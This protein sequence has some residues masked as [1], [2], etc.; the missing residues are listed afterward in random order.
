VCPSVTTTYK[1]R[2]VKPDSSQ[3]S[4]EVM[5][6]VSGGGCG[7]PVIERFV[8]T[9][10]DVAAGKPFSVFWDVECAKSVQYIKGDGPEQSVGTHGSRIDETVDSDT[11]FRLRVEKNTGGFV[12]A[13]FVVRAN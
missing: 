10:Y 1:A 5:V 11:T 6:N 9:T 3:Q 7:D 8:P 13:S 2:V 12:Y 4:H